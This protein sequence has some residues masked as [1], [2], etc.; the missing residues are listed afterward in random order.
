[1]KKTFLF[2]ITTIITLV[3]KANTFDN[4]RFSWYGITYKNTLK[5]YQKEYVGKIVKYFPQGKNGSSRDDKHF[6][7]KGGDYNNEYTIKNIYG[8]STYLSFVLVNNETNKTMRFN[9]QNY[10]PNNDRFYLDKNDK[11]ITLP[12]IILDRLNEHKKRYIN[13]KPNGTYISDIYLNNSSNNQYPSIV[14]E[15]L[16]TSDNTKYTSF[17]RDTLDLTHIGKTIQSP[18][19]SYLYSVVGL[20]YSFI[21][22][23]A[24]KSYLLKNSINKRIKE[25]FN[26]DYTKDAFK[27]DDSGIYFTNL[28]KVEKPKNQDIRYGD[29]SIITD[30]ITKFGYLDN[31]IDISIFTTQTQFVFSIK[32]VSENTIKVI[33][34][35][36]VFVDVDSSTSKVMHSGTKYSEREGNQPASVIIKGAKLDDNVIPT[37]KVYYSDSLEKWSELSLFSNA[38]KNSNGQIIRLMLP[39]QIKDVI[40]EYIFDFGINFKY[41]HPELVVEE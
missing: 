3:L 20:N 17:I 21:N 19:Y 24:A 30:S 29:T 39:I 31:I 10:K 34:N 26:D 36:A 27:G 35:E 40:N 41:D 37:N 7:K 1:M 12:F 9:V 38:D 23:S 11:S 5:E 6:I 4:P 22:N 25:L 13:I 14:A 8:S 28:L 16:D 15:V 18:Q 32:N 2:I 33:W